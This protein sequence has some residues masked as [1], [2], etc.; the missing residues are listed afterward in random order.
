MA[1]HWT[2]QHAGFKA[3][4]R[5]VARWAETVPADASVLDLA[6]GSGRHGRLFL[7]RGHPVTLLD[8]NIAGVADL[9][10]QAELIEADL[11]TDHGWPLGDRR[12][13]VIVVTCYLHR[14]ILDDI[15]EALAPEGLLIYETFAHGNEAYGH[16]ARPAYLLQAGE[17]LELARG[18]LTV[19]GYE[20]GYDEDPKPGIR[21]RIA[22]RKDPNA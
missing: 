1:G 5:W 3:P 18:R 2:E 10:A 9:T 22:A 17:L 13:G 11:E 8:R 4:S 14:P 12:F 6:C 20:H 19:L 16:P 21:Q 15:V 7:D